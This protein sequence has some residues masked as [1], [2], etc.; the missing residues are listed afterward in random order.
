MY[1][2]ERFDD[3]A[4][5]RAIIRY[6][7]SAQHSGNIA[8]SEGDSMPDYALKAT[9]YLQTI[10]A[11]DPQTVENAKRFFYPSSN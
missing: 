6:F 2:S 7:L 1:D 3:L 5:K 10:T 11:L 8:V 9:A 4:I